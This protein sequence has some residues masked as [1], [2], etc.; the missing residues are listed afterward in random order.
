M[1]KRE[2]LLGDYLRFINT[3]SAT[4]E[5]IRSVLASETWF[6]TLLRIVNID[7]TMGVPKVSSLKTRLLALQVLGGIMAELSDMSSEAL[8]KC[9]KVGVLS[10]S[11][12]RCHGLDYFISCFS[13]SKLSM[14]MSVISFV[15]RPLVLP[16]F[17][18]YMLKSKRA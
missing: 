9:S 17:L 10:H 5:A 18:Y 16:A 1:D 3:L 7:T 15:S 2:D 13:H 14:F 6:G 11:S 4:H 8:A 12:F